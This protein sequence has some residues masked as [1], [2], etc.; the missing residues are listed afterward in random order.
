MNL[1]VNPSGSIG[2][3]NH[4]IW[5]PPLTGNNGMTIIL[6]DN[7]VEF[8]TSYNTTGEC[9]LGNEFQLNENGLLDVVSLFMEDNNGTAT[10]SIEI[11]DGNHNSLYSSEPF[12]PVFGAWT[13]V[14][15]P[16]VEFNGTFFVMLHMQVIGNS[17]YLA[18][19][20]DGACAVLCPAWYTDNL[21]EWVQLSDLGFEP[22]VAFI[23]AHAITGDKKKSVT[24]NPGPAVSSSGSAF[25]PA[26]VSK[27]VNVTT[28]SEVSHSTLTTVNSETLLGYDIYRRAYALFP[29]GPNTSGTGVWT[30]IN[31][32]LVT[33][34]EYLDQNLSNLEYNCYEYRVTAQY[35]TAESTP[36][37]RK[38]GCIFTNLKPDQANQVNLYPNPASTFI[39]I[40]LNSDF[41][42]LNIINSL[43]ILVLEKNILGESSLVL[44]TSDYSPGL[45][46]VRF[47]NL[48]GE[49]VS[50]KFIVEL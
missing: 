49:W 33:Q 27:P 44:N 29:A 50:R 34:T 38:S 24:L 40:K 2:N 32:A 48:K 20:Q 41:S 39:S 4:L 19:D 22:S 42:N 10:Y 45:Y 3:E 18:L 30:Q 25:A 21:L 31:P 6:N 23:R 43:G 47:S 16:F 11:F 13:N 46:T 9:W 12:T 8:N 26:L 7:S 28:G 17:D 35:E 1:V 5:E 14:E 37:Y 15:L 36:T